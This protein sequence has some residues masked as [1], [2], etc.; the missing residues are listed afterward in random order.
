MPPSAARR[1]ASRAQKRVGELLAALAA[2]HVDSRASLAAA[3][4]ADPTFLRR[5][6]VAWLSK[7]GAHLLQGL[8]PRLFE[9]A[10]G[11]TVPARVSGT[12]KKK[13]EERGVGT[14][15]E[16]DR[17]VHGKGRGEKRKGRQA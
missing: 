10:F 16:R 2:R 17:S 12:G 3:W 11:G 1:V 14:G 13:A 9:E 4:R 7:P 15:K 8:W 6:L 5:E